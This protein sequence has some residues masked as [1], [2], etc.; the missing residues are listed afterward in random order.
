PAPESPQPPSSPPAGAVAVAA[1]VALEL[2]SL[3][4]VWPAVLDELKSSGNTICAHRL[5]DAQPIAVDGT[6]VTVAFSPAG[7]SA[8]Y[9]MRKADGEEDRACVAEAIRT[10]T[11]GVKPQIAYVLGQEAA[12]VADAAPVPT[13]SEWVERFVAEFDA[14]EIHPESEAS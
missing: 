3:R 7:E 14:E 12:A 9:N 8:D 10:L 13:D 4:A 2:E 5:A 1:P 11:G 6:H